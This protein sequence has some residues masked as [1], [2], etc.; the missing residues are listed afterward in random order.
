MGI[1]IRQSLKASIVTYLGTAIGT[2][3]V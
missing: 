2:F 3:N 1:V